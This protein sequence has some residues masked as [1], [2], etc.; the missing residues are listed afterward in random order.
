MLDGYKMKINDTIKY[1]GYVIYLFD[2]DNL[3]GMMKPLTSIPPTLRWKNTSEM[4]KLDKPALYID[5]LPV[6]LVLRGYPISISFQFIENNE[7][8]NMLDEKGQ[9]V[10]DKDG[11]E[12]MIKRKRLTEKGQSSSEIE[13]QL[14]S[15]YVNNVFRKKMMDSTVWIVFVLW[16]LLCIIITYVV[17]EIIL[18]PK[19]PS[20]DSTGI[21]NSTTNSTKMLW[22]LKKYG[23]I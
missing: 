23:I 16:S 3:T 13:A 12:I 22:S 19:T 21:I 2:S 15:M 4:F 11:K 5:G 9:K 20:T 6:F 8:V 7:M 10:L 17:C 18:N 1:S 14:R